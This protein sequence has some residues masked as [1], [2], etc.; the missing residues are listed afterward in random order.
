MNLS[1][2]FAG[3]SLKNPVLVASGTF[4]YGRE[5][6]PL[7]DLSRLGGIMVKGVSNVPWP[8]NAG[9]RMAETS[10]GMLNAIGLQNPGLHHFLETDLPWLRTFDTAIIVNVVGYA[11]EEYVEVTQAVSRAEGVSAVELNVSCPNIKGGLSF[12]TDPLGLSGLVQA[13]RKV[14]KVPLIVKL[15]P[16]VT[17]IKPLAQAAVDSGADALSLINTL[18]GMAI[19][20]V[21]REP[22]LGRVTGGLSGPAIKPVALRFVYEVATQ[23][24][25]PIIGMGGITSEDDAMEFLYAG[26]SA[27]AVG[28]ALFKDPWAALKIIE[29]MGGRLEKEGFEKVTEATGL[30]LPKGRNHRA[31]R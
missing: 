30:A 1:V 18:L 11:V 27:I 29:G 5:F 16:N 3:L 25:I 28:T 22:V 9:T 15:S 24:D 8:G 21:T 4:G 26:A 6:A 12:G 23:M 13:V 31:G 2:K 10:Q 17:D 14:C 20:P 19:D 7:F